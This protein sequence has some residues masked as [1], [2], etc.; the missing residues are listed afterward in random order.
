MTVKF[1]F[2]RLL[3]VLFTVTG[4]P[5]AAFAENI[6]TE[7]LSLK[8]ENSILFIEVAKKYPTVRFSKFQNPNKVLIELLES[9][10]HKNF[11]LDSNEKKSLL[12]GTGFITDLTAGEEK[13]ETDKLKISIVLTLK[14]NFNPHPR[15]VS[16]KDNLIKISFE[17]PTPVVQKKEEIKPIEPEID[18]SFEPVR[19]VYN[20]AVTENLSGNIEKAGDLY[21]EAIVKN[22]DFYPARYNLAKLYFDR[23]NFIQSKELIS[24]LIA[25][26]QAKSTEISDQR[27]MLLSRNLLGQIFLHENS[28][29]KAIDQFNEITKTDPSNY[30]AYFLLGIANEKLKN[31]E[32]AVLNFK[33]VI[34]IKSDFPPALYHLGILNSI[35]NNKEEAISNL[36]R[37]IALTPESDL[38][39]LSLEE[40][41]KLDRKKYRNPK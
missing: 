30:E 6:S 34:E 29:D 39:K 32:A 12:A 24:A 20:N 1:K 8:S 40:L 13:H 16:T 37:V 26:I 2:L 31:T 14:E 27:I 23:G 28:I 38:G 5:N 10:Y 19:E 4:F 17:E 41:Q 18:T 21:I 3:I 25:D 11:K 22:K 15:I 7:V 35:L 9:K 36:E 33:K